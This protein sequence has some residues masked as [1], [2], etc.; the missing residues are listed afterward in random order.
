[1][2]ESSRVVYIFSAQDPGLVLG[3]VGTEGEGEGVTDAR[4]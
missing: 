4:C 1:M 3:A 2:S